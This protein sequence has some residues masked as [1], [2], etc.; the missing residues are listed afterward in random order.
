MSDEPFIA[1]ASHELR[2]PI[3]GIVGAAETLD[4]RWDRL[5]ECD[6]RQLVGLL[7]RQSRRLSH[8][9]DELLELSRL[10][11]GAVAV[12]VRPVNVASEAVAAIEEAGVGDVEVSVSPGPTVIADANHL[13]RI[14]V[15]LL[16]NADRHGA[17]PIVV[18]AVAAGGWVEVRVIDA[19]PGVPGDFVP[20]LFD[21]FTRAEA[22]PS[23][24]GLGLAIVESLARL[25][26]GEVFYRPGP[27]GGSMFGVRLPPG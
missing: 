15:N 25:D 5:S 9:V 13:R 12:A 23:G 24:A 19:G 20:R 16:V 26:G 3:A 8:L 4:G 2:T 6:R 27:K 14:L 22:A 10:E 7:V 18:E 21:R 17:R 11:A 1:V